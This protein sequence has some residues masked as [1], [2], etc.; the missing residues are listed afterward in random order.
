M[1]VSRAVAPL[2]HL[3][4]YTVPLLKTKG[5]FVALKGNLDEELLNIKNY[6]QK[7]YLDNEKIVT[8][9]LPIEESTR[10]IYS[11]TKVKET[12]LIY[13]RDYSQIKKREL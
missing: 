13:P 1:A 12:P 3:L 4:E 8:F 5:T 10:S 9:K 11:I 6:Y 7:L 2:K